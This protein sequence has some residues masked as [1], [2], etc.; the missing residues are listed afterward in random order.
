MATRR[1]CSLWAVQTGTAKR[2][3]ALA[4]RLWPEGANVQAWARGEEREARG[5]CE[6]TRT[7]CSPELAPDR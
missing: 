4:V 1:A 6:R 3:C 5:V 7:L 2:P